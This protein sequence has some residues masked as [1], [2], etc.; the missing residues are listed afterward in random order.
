[1]RRTAVTRPIRGVVL[2]HLLDDAVAVEQCTDLR[3]A[4]PAVSTR[5]ADAADTSGG[6][7][8]RDRLRVDAE[9]CGHL[10]RCQQT[11]CSVHN[12]LLASVCLER[13]VVT[14]SVGEL[15]RDVRPIRALPK[16]Q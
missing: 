3:L 14:E 2:T 4:E 11:I 12:P 6:G 7:P 8:A 5:S 13:P 9:Q 15:D 10:A 16:N 1:M